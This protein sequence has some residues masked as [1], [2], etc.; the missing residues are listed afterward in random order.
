[1]FLHTTHVEPRPGH[2]LFVRFNNGMAGELSLAGELWGE[3]FEPLKDPA[4]FATARHDEMAGTVVWANG[5]DLA[6]EFLL[7]L[8]EAQARQAA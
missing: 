6:P 3:M 8:L 2:R 5:A 1:M 4:L 7:Q